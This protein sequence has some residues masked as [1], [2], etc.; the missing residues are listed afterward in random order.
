MADIDSH[1]ES[2]G[3]IES[4]KQNKVACFNGVLHIECG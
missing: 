1:L 2:T 4:S 3:S